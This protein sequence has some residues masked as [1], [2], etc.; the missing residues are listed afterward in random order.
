MPSLHNAS[1]VLLGTHGSSDADISCERGAPSTFLAGLAVRRG[2]DGALSLT[3]G[4][5][6]GVSLGISMSD[7]SRTSV[8]RAG[9]LIPLRLTS[10]SG[11]AYV[12]IGSVVRVSTTTGQAT[13]AGSVTGAIYVSGPIKGIDPITKEEIDV[14]LIDM[15][16]GL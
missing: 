16:G 10:E 1:K 15:N 14:A 5:L 3:V 4:S 13:S 2:T 8:C 6:I 12:T 9:N 7:T 11:F